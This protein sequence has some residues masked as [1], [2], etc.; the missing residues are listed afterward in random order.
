MPTDERV[1]RKHLI[2]SGRVQGVGF[3]WRARQAA[4]AVGATGWVR[5]DLR[6]TVSMELQGTEEQLDRV[7]DMLGRARWISIEDCNARRIPVEA[8]E[9]SFITK[10]DQW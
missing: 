7:I 6:G 10:D 9:R 5:N 8:D 4:E 2:F 3:R 1:I